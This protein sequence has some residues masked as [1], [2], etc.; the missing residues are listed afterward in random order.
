MMDLKS[1]QYGISLGLSGKPLPISGGE[2]SVPDQP[3]PVAYLYNGVRLPKLPE[4]DRETYPYA[5]IYGTES[6]G[7]L[8]YALDVYST[9]LRLTTKSSGSVYLGVNSSGEYWGV[10]MYGYP[11]SDEP[12]NTFENYGG[13]MI[14]GTDSGSMQYDIV[15]ANSDVLN[16]DGSVYLAASDPI[17]VYE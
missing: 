9:P 2:P 17:P 13:R 12:R 11:W 15:W 4:W 1:L 16:E 10:S 7:N 8:V 6:N 5:V 3:E 14:S